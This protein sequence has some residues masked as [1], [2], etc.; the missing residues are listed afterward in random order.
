MDRE[1]RIAAWAVARCLGSEWRY[2]R[3]DNPGRFHIVH[4]GGHG[5]SF[6]RM[7]ND[8]SR[9]R[10]APLRRYRRDEG[11]PGEITASASRSFGSIAAD[12]QRRMIAAGLKQAHDDDVAADRARRTEIAARF[13]AITAVAK[14]AGGRIRD[15]RY[16][17]SAGYPEAD[18][19]G[20]L[21]KWGYGDSIEFE[22]RATPAQAVQIAERLASISQQD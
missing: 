15:K 10:I 20:G 5:V 8:S 4:R 13:A 19:L 22:I 7:W 17:K 12:I 16:W 2:E 14:A 3:E 18:V 1:T 11:P 9:F 21:A 6:G